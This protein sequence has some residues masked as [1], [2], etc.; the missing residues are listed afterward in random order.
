MD[1]NISRRDALC[2]LGAI[3]LV[4]MFTPFAATAATSDHVLGRLTDVNTGKRFQPDNR[5]CLAVTMTAQEL[6]SDCGRS[7]VAIATVME[8]LENSKDNIR[9]ILIMPS[10][11]RQ[12]DPSEK[13]NLKRATITYADLNYTILT[14]NLRVLEDLSQKQK[15]QSAFEI[16]HSK[17]LVTGHTRNVFFMTS[18]KGKVLVNSPPDGLALLGTVKGLLAACE[19]PE[20]LVVCGKM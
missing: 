2:G 10:L 6:Y 12:P 16:E 8:Y 14:G 13:G 20:N 18:D 4:P 9:P 5:F 19:K 7:F 17:R 3:S 11:Q 15:L 1:Q